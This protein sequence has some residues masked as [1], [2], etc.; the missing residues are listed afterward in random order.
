MS[1]RCH[2]AV[3]TLSSRRPWPRVVELAA[4][5]LLLAAYT[6]LWATSA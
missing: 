1:D 5:A 3:E 6:A 2:V 4:M